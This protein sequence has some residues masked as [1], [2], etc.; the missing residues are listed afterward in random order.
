M[1]EK[2]QPNC[3]AEL[4]IILPCFDCFGTHPKKDGNRLNCCVSAQDTVGFLIKSTLPVQIGLACRSHLCLFPER[5]GSQLFTDGDVVTGYCWVVC[6]VT[7]AGALNTEGWPGKSRKTSSDHLRS[8]TAYSPIP[9]NCPLAREIT[10]RYRRGHIHCTC[11]AHL[12][13][14]PTKWRQSCYCS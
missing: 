9:T 8:G 10:F 11:K 6:H 2:S 3:A 7:D 4:N 12:K 1:P 5:C 14:V 13:I